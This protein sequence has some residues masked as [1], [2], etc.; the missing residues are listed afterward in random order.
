MT[1][2]RRF[3][4]SLATDPFVAFDFVLG[5]LV[6][7]GKT[8][9]PIVRAGTLGAILAELCAD[10]LFR[11]RQEILALGFPAGVGLRQPP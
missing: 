6:G 7:N 8:L 3:K 5:L 2:R 1:V 10:L 4:V 11:F 9:R